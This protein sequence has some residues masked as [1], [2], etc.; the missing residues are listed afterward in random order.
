MELYQ[1][2]TFRMV[3]QEGH[4]TRAAKRLNASQPAVSAHIKTLEDKLGVS[5]FLRTPT[6]MVLTPNGRTLLEHAI[7][8]L[9]VIDEMAGV[10]EKLQG[11]ISGNLKIGMNTEPDSLKI[12][13]FFSTM[14]NIHPDIK[15]HL[16]QSM[17]GD[18]L[19]KLEDGLLDAGFMYG[20][21]KSDNMFTVELQQLP[22]VVAG[23][24]PWS[25]LLKNATPKD[26][27][28]FPW[29][30]TPD[31]CPFHTVTL[32]I[33]KKYDIQPEQIAFVDQES[34]LKTI[35]RAG[36]GVSLVLEQDTRDFGENEL[37]I[38]KNE[39][40]FLPLSIGCLERR[41]EEPLLQTL[42]SLLTRIWEGSE[43]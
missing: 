41:K 34:T 15:L 35:M 7:H 24:G 30:M 28:T 5:L 36:V 26:L 32:R 3:A 23:S 29:I 16:L 6:G 14:K 12:P 25:N 42:F 11:N 21:N 18:L 17:T 40:F 1:L 27:G 8:A 13:D 31:N 39:D 33:F 2:R 43:N 4:L 38:W 10:A 37:S 22:V 19:N 20:N 9:A